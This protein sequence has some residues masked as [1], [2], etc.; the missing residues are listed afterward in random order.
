MTE[1]AGWAALK[2]LVAGA[3]CSPSFPTPLSV[4]VCSAKMTKANWYGIRVLAPGRIQVGRNRRRECSQVVDVFLTEVL[5]AERVHVKM[6][7][8]G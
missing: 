2:S 6:H 7:L 3:D 4:P 5:G 1:T 8:E